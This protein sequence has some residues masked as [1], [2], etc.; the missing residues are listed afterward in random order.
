MKIVTLS[1]YPVRT[2]IHGGQR[3]LDAIIRVL[4]RAGHQVSDIPLFFSSHYPQHDAAE[5]QTAVEPA[6]ELEVARRRLAPDVHLHRL[7]DAESTALQAAAARIAE[8]KPDVLHF[9]QPWLM[10][11]LDRLIARLPDGHRVFVVY[12]SQ[13]IE[14]ELA[15]G[16]LTDEVA[17]IES[18]AVRRA[19]MVVAVSDADATHLARLAP[20]NRRPKIVVAPNASWPPD[21]D[22]TH[23]RIVEGDYVMMV[24][25]YHAP[26]AE[27]FWKVIGEVPGCIPPDGKLVVAGRVC[28]LLAQDPRMGRFH[29]LRGDLVRFVGQ[30]DDATLAA[31]LAHAK[32]LLLP[33]VSGGGTNLKTAEALLSLKPV[34]G[35]RAAFRGYENATGLSGVA[36]AD[37]PEEFRAAVRDIFSGT[38]TSARRPEDVEK[39]TWS[40][41]LAALPAAYEA[42]VADRVA[43]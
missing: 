11:L 1:N 9:E 22:A 36:V 30:V 38:L 23:P 25:S 17:R 21:P 43:G 37:T 18:D 5:A 41:T 29:R 34:V 3:R 15:S 8:F 7:L 32:G 42:L 2:P 12:G 19:D 20:A 14:T 27:G 39:Y 40:A 26:N 35:M 33:I 6:V 16:P 4:R 24:G 13:N 28:D 10:P 31:L